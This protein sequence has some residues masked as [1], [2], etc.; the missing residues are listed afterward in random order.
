VAHHASSWVDSEGN[1]TRTRQQLQGV[2]DAGDDP[3]HDLVD[4]VGLCFGRTQIAQEQVLQPEHR[5]WR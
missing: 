2:V 3:D 1:W 5:S 4:A